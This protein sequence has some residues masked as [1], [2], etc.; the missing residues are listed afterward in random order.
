MTLNGTTT[1]NNDNTDVSGTDRLTQEDL[2]R[3]EPCAVK[4]ACTVLRGRRRSNAPL[5]P[6]AYYAAC[7][8]KGDKCPITDDP[9]FQVERIFYD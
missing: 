9:W 4:V 7:I 3:L 6:D 8:S 2:E 1:L 5:L